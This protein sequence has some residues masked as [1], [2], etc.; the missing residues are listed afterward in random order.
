M[1][2]CKTIDIFKDQIP[3][4]FFQ[5]H[6]PNDLVQDFYQQEIL[7]ETKDHLPE[8]ITPQILGDGMCT[9][10]LYLKTKRNEYLSSLTHIK[11]AGSSLLP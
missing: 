2:S 11:V 1:T 3:N 7:S 9:P 5:D 4:D 10:Y 8:M 6:L